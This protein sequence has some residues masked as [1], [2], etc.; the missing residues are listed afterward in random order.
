[1]AALAASAVTSWISGQWWI[2][3]LGVLAGV[4]IAV[5]SAMG[6]KEDLASQAVEPA[7]DL[8]LL[9]PALRKRFNALLEKKQEIS[10]A[11]GDLKDSPYLSCDDIEFRVQDL[12]DSYYD[13]I[14][15]LEKIRPFIQRKSMAEA[16]KSVAGLKK[17]LKEPGDEVTRENLTMALENKT[18]QL[19]RLLEMQSYSRRINSQLINLVSALN[20][21]YLRIVQL[22]VS[23]NSSIDHTSEIT[24][25]INELILDVDISEKV[26]R[27]I[28]CIKETGSLR[29][30]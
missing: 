11:L 28:Q 17:R 30:T 25:R 16:K 22:R 18:D 4:V 24:D 15:K 3:A 6:E 10:V 13:L 26:A 23:P 1:M 19:N 29:K 8:S 9:D 7:Y 5:Q 27:E 20:N 2:V 21:I 12:V 14:L